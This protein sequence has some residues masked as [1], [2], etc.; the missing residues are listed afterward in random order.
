M[1]VYGC[2]VLVPAAAHCRF[3]AVT[4]PLPVWFCGSAVCYHTTHARTTFTPVTRRLL[5]G[6]H[7]RTP[8]PPLRH[9]FTAFCTVGFTFVHAA[10]TRS[11][12]V[13]GLVTPLHF[14]VCR[15]RVL[16]THALRVPLHGLRYRLL[17][18]T[19]LPHTHCGSTV[20][21]AVLR[22]VYFAVFTVRFCVALPHTTAYIHTVCIWLPLPLHHRVR[23]GLYTFW[24]HAHTAPHRFTALRF[25]HRGSAPR[26]TRHGLG[27]YRFHGLRFTVTVY[28]CLHLRYHTVAFTPHRTRLRLHAPAHGFTFYHTFT[29]LLPTLLPRFAFAHRYGYA[30]LVTHTP[31]TRYLR[32]T[33][34]YRLRLPLRLPVYGLHTH[35]RLRL[36]RTRFTT[37]CGYYVYALHT[38]GLRTRTR[39][40]FARYAHCLYT[41]HAHTHTHHAWIRLRTLPHCVLAFDHHL[42]WLVA[43]LRLRFALRCGYAHRTPLRFY[44]RS[45]TYTF[46]VWF[47]RIQL[48][49]RTVCPHYT[50]RFTTTVAF[51]V[52]IAVTPVCAAPHAR[53][54]TVLHARCLYATLP[55][56][57][58]LPHAPRGLR[59]GCGYGLRSHLPHWLR[60]PAVTGFGSLHYH[61]MVRYVTH[62]AVYTAGYARFTG[63]VLLP[64]TVLP[65]SCPVGS[66]VTLHCH[67]VTCRWVWF[68]AAHCATAWFCLF[69]FYARSTFYVRLLPGLYT[70]LPRTVT[71]PRLPRLPR[72]HRYAVWFRLRYTF[73]TRAPSC[74]SGFCGYT[75]FLRFAHTP[76]T[77]SRL[78]TVA[79]TVFYTV[80][81][82]CTVTVPPHLR[83]CGFFT[84]LPVRLLG[85]TRF[86][87][88]QFWLGLLRFIPCTTTDCLPARFTTVHCLRFWVYAPHAVTHLPRFYRV[89][90]RFTHSST[91]SRTL[92]DSHG[93]VLYHTLP[94]LPCWLRYAVCSLPALP[95]T[96]TLPFTVLLL[97]STL[98][99]RLHFRFVTTPPPLRVCRTRLRF[100][101]T[102]TAVT[103]GSTFLHTAVAALLVY[104]TFTLH[105]TVAAPL[106]V[107]FTPQFT[108]T[109]H[110]SGFCRG[111]AHCV[112]LPHLSPVYARCW[113]L[114]RYWFVTRLPHRFWFLRLRARW[115]FTT[116]TATVLHTVVFCR[117]LPRLCR[118]THLRGCCH[119][120]RCTAAVRR[121]LLPC[122]LVATVYCGCRLCTRFAATATLLPAVCGSAAVAT[123]CLLPHLP[124][125]TAHT[126]H[127]PRTARIPF[128]CQLPHTTVHGYT[129]CR[130]GFFCGFTAHL[131]PLVRWFTATHYCLGSAH[132]R[133]YWL[134]Y[135]L[136]RQLPAVTARFARL[137]L[138]CG[139]G[140]SWLPFCGLVLLPPAGSYL[141]RCGYTCR[142]TTR[143][144]LP[145]HAVLHYRHH[146]GLRL[147]VHVYAVTHTAFYTTHHRTAP[148]CT[149]HAPVPY[150]THGLPARTATVPLLPRFV[151]LLPLRGYA[152]CA[153]L[154][155]LV[156]YLPHYCRGCPYAGYTTVLR[157]TT[158]SGYRTVILRTFCR[159]PAVTTLVCSSAHRWL[160]FG[161]LLPLRL[162]GSRL[163]LHRTTGLR[164]HYHTLFLHYTV[165]CGYHP[166]H[167]AFCLDYG[168][169]TL[170]FTPPLHA[171]HGLHCRTYGSPH[172][173]PRCTRTVGLPHATTHTAQLLPHTGYRTRLPC[174]HCGLRCRYH[175]VACGLRTRTPLL[176]RLH[177]HPHGFAT[178]VL[179]Y[180]T[181][182]HC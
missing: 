96:R 10:C 157:F 48:G 103:P 87:L 84:R 169:Y 110:G 65:G 172:H 41:P 181:V 74:G 60:T 28:G 156:R 73:A 72:T 3:T 144:T 101:H 59:T 164:L 116:H 76:H 88:P 15:T 52:G 62:C 176:R 128:A 69:W 5:V 58:L 151:T 93:L 147:R 24:V 132:L 99:L 119:A 86:A 114:L 89:C 149:L 161:Y 108:T 71:L 111:Y 146:L 134:P 49:S 124:P 117:W 11:T 42:G 83:T 171:P 26:R 34:G 166:F 61:R 142:F 125:H 153:V 16:P 39:T 70:V 6:L 46:H 91:G 167:R 2:Y 19:A 79:V 35:T 82:R 179:Y 145:H 175:T 182:P 180:T 12:A 57:A 68:T 174:Y 98:G 22:W 33:H 92:L 168:C 170:R 115:F 173:P 113:F 165:Y 141:H 53:F 109:V 67:A 63:Y 148:P 94:P 1:H 136:H 162:R 81:L 18:V 107:W 133:D 9:T 90:R 104:Y 150:H 27:F 121:R 106:Q 163:R 177:A 159:A 97:P 85:F 55:Y 13:P 44:L 4:L 37:G 66:R 102:H 139:L 130:T 129:A 140:Y 45:T 32:F 160:L 137:H 178:L 25:V 23:S 75:R 31:H 80:G 29:T 51:T 100:T 135:V 158:G 40:R 122:V 21:S 155:G 78:V 54:Y 47:L 95:H 77:G 123:I 126:L 14:T 131:I 143:F 43:V 20:G 64:T 105:R 38:C 56:T 118:F 127:T 112:P 120:A 152:G 36:H 30:R 50:H 138:P 8:A 7:P 17:P 154:H